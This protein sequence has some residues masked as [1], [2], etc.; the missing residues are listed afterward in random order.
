MC[1]KRSRLHPKSGLGEVDFSFRYLLQLFVERAFVWWNPLILCRLP[2]LL[3]LFIFLIL[4]ILLICRNVASISTRTHIGQLSSDDERFSNNCT[5][6]SYIA[7]SAR[8]QRRTTEARSICTP[9]IASTYR[10]VFGSAS[11]GS[12]WSVHVSGTICWFVRT[13]ETNGAI[14]RPLCTTE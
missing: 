6:K 10:Y 4:L 2:K 12:I 8:Q 11:G 5:A 1:K 9:Y 13:R 3:M 7:C 14:G